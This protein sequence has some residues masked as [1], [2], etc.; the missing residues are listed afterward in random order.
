M[1]SL[2]LFLA[3]V[4]GYFLT[5]LFRVVNAVAGPPVVAEFGLDAASFGFITSVYFLTYAAI[6][7]PLG[8]LLD[9]YGPH[10]VEGVL[11][12]IAAVGTTIFA[13]SDSVAMLAI[14]RA[15]MGLGV[16]AGLM[17]AF[18]AYAALVPRE[19]LPLVNG[20]H[21]ATGSLGVL[22]GGLPLEF[23]IGGLGWRGAFIVLAALAAFGA[24]ALLFGVRNFPRSESKENLGEQVREAGRL[25]IAPA[26][27]RIAPVAAGTQA[28]MAALQALWVGPFLR[29]VAGYSPTTA[30]TVISCMGI[31]VIIGYAASGGVAHQL[32]KRGIPLAAVMLGGC[33][34]VLAT[35]SAIVL[36]NPSWSAPLWVALAFFG[37]F[38]ALSYA[39][40]SQNFPVASAGRVNATI[41]FMV[42]V[43][44]FVLQWSFGVIVSRLTGGNG[45]EFAFDVA[46]GSLVALQTF[47]FVWYFLFRPRPQRAAD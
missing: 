6:Q 13:L 32:V 17:A 11:L 16:S 25:M 10:R 5:Q 37:C 23:L 7:L 26:F 1:I 39:T 19:R 27:V 18:R 38:P 2:S 46:L 44:S 14:G 36:I 4:L 43:G 41:N 21:M 20:I 29:E 22:A 40:I 8:V 35:L 3:F 30:A 33:F 47:G 24:A 45:V 42:F 34:T 28:S 12:L 15:L 31:A 9:R